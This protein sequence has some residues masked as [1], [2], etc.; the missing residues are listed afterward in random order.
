MK[1][2]VPRREEKQGIGEESEARSL[3][4]LSR[5]WAH[6]FSVSVLFPLKMLIEVPRLCRE[7]K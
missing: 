3:K 7:L 4:K 1:E 5:V 2:G 6:V